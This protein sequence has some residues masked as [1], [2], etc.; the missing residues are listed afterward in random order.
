MEGVTSNSRE[1]NSGNKQMI[2]GGGPESVGDE[3]ELPSYECTVHSERVCV[4]VVSAMAYSICYRP[5]LLLGF[6]SLNEF[7]RIFIGLYHVS[8]NDVGFR[9]CIFS[10][11]LS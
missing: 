8:C 2:G 4:E 7:G 1:L 3:R 11:D 5:S 9:R 10:G 6:I